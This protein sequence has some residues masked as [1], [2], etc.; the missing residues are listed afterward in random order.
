MCAWLC[1]CACRPT[2]CCGFQ[3]GAREPEVVIR[4]TSTCAKVKDEVRYNF[5]SGVYEVVRDQQLTL[6][7]LTLPSRV[8]HKGDYLEAQMRHE[9]RHKEQGTMA[10]ILRDAETI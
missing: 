4:L 6:D 10:I 3:Q 9:P 7:L 5:T 8:I 2:T 1:V